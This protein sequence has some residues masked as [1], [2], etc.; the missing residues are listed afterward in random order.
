MQTAR[1]VAR[2]S[3]SCSQRQQL[4]ALGCG[5]Y[6][7]EHGRSLIVDPLRTGQTFYLPPPLTTANLYIAIEEQGGKGALTQLVSDGIGQPCHP[8][9]TVPTVPA[10]GAEVW[11]PDLAQASFKLPGTVVATTV[12]LTAPP[13]LT[14]TRYLIVRQDEAAVLESSVI[15]SANDPN[16]TLPEWADTF[17][18]VIS[19]AFRKAACPQCRCVDFAI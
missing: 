2:L 9:Y 8:F 19:A 5:W 12:S 16:D 10:P 17:T 15:L 11:H 4:E 7:V 14:L 1:I 3:N 18:A 6:E 13:L